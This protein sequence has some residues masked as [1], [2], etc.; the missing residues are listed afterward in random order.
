MLRSMMLCAILSFCVLGLVA[1]S[2]DEDIVEV[3]QY[4]ITIVNTIDTNYQVWIDADIDT[5]GFVR[6]GDLGANA[7]RVFLDRTI[8][9]GYTFRLTLDGQDPDADEFEHHQEIRSDGANITWEVPLV[10]P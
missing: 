7:T 1:C 2:D 5:D 8:A 4:D 10:V 6:D 3:V 9:V